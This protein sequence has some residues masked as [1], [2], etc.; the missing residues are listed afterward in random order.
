MPLGTVAGVEAEFASLTADLHKAR[1][2][3]SNA[4][5]EIQKIHLAAASVAEEHQTTLIKVREEQHGELDSLRAA[6]L[7][8]VAAVSEVIEGMLDEVMKISF[9]GEGT[10]AR[11]HALYLFFRRIVE[12]RKKR[13]KMAADILVKL[14][15]IYGKVRKVRFEAHLV[16]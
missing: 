15:K 6:A 7:Q 10:A 9:D 16:Q 2:K 8:R 13:K 12:A 1:E 11:H 3:T 5:A 4:I 14:R